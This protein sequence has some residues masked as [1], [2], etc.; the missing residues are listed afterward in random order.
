MVVLK[1]GG[2]DFTCTGA[3]MVYQ[4]S[5]R[6]TVGVSSVF[7]SFPLALTGVA[8]LGTDNRPAL[9]K[10]VGDLDGRLQQTAGI[11]PEVEHQASHPL[12]LSLLDRFV[13]ITR[14]GA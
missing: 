10:H 7:G 11:E 13:Q 12:F 1:R 4:D 14:R 5:E 9:K 8:P 3:T 2:N 6:K